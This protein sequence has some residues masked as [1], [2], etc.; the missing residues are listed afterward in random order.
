M[1]LPPLCPDPLVITLPFATPKEKIPKAQ[2]RRYN[3]SKTYLGA[4]LLKKPIQLLQATA[5][6]Y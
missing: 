2:L 5:D 1:E 4:I 3:Y 6:I